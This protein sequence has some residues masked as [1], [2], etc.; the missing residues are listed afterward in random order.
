MA[1]VQGAPAEL[2]SFVG[3]ARE[4]ADIR[5]AL[6]ATRLLTLTGA[7]GSGKTRLALEVGA[8]EAA[9][10]GAA[11][12]WV[13]LAPVR[14]PALVAATVLA[15]LGI[16]DDSRL[17][18]LERL[19]RVI[20]DRTFTL[21]LDNC[22]HLVEASAALVDALLRAC[23]RLRVLVTSR[24]SLGV[25][26]ETA[27]LVPPLSL[28]APDESAVCTSEAVQL[29]VQRARAVTPGFELPAENRHAVVH[30]CRRLDGLPLA[31][32]LAA[33]RLR[34]LTPQQIAERLDDRF[35]LLRTG[36]RSALPRHQ[37][38][39]ATMD[40]SHDLLDEHERIALA[41]LSVFGGS[42]GI[43]AA[44]SV[45]AGG[46]I[47]GEDVLD[48]VAALVEKSLITM[49]ESDDIARYRLLETVREYAAERLEQR[50]E[51]GEC[52]RR[53]AQFFVALVAEAEPHLTTAARPGWLA[54]LDA[55]LDNIRQTLAWTREHDPESYVQ[56]T[57]MLHWFWFAS[58]QWP[59]ALQ[60]LRGALSLPAAA[61]RSHERAALLFSIGSILT[62]QASGD[63]CAYLE[64][65][66][67]IADELAD[68]R[69]VA[70]ARNYLGIARTQVGDASAE[71][72]VR[73]AHD[74]FRAANDLY[75]L[76]LSLLLLGTAHVLRGDVA[77]AVE[78]TEDG[79]RV[80]RIF[81][82]DRE[83]AIAL[84][85]LAAM[86][87]RRGDV[88]RATTLL[89]EALEALRRDPQRFFLARALEL[90]A[91]CL[92]ARGGSLD[93]A[94]LYGAAQAIRESIG[95]EIWGF[96][97]DQQVPH[98][99]AAEQSVGVEAFGVA[100][101]E[102]H[103]LQPAEAI[104]LA[105]RV[106]PALVPAREPDPSTNTAE[107]EV[108]VVDDGVPGRGT[109]PSISVRA[110]GPLEIAVDDAPLPR[111]SWGYAKARELLVFLLLYPEGRTR[112]QI[113]AAL[114][115]DASTAQVRNNFHVT[116]HH[117][118][119][120]L[121]RTQWIRFERDRYCV[122]P[123]GVVDFD[124][125]TFEAGVT[126][127][128]RLGRRGTLPLDDLGA[129]LALYRGPFLE[130]E[131]AGDWHL[132]W[133]DRF[134]RLNATGLEALGTALISRGLYDDA[135]ASFERLV[136]QEELHEPAYRSLIIARAR[137]GD[138]SG[139]MREYRRL[140][141]VLQREGE[142][143]PRAETQAIFRRVARGEAV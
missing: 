79:V 110:L 75:G 24:Q 118:R 55:E 22:E 54:R 10:S 126:N 7:G 19:A 36:N 51:V 32:E 84:Q 25:A 137:A 93:A 53:H 43:D 8:R 69:L 34:V 87:L 130:S 96:D 103:A 134:A 77:R 52:H 35:R 76:R 58:G 4:V 108:A 73:R 61:R 98:L 60:W 5:R 56:S 74:W 125:A 101:A 40:W 33:A 142:A 62:M 109:A 105:L 59:E 89:G 28:P 88:D 44:E 124:A 114:W 27:W 49:V 12:A 26:G 82:L 47:A 11:A 85:Q 135:A 107:F 1:T 45:C 112:E 38:L 94:R 92:A 50:G 9:A 63:G 67:A 37:T 21:I 90:M 139:A 116:L 129:A 65:A 131:P 64:E 138:R 119:R 2:T 91:M 141:A 72:P 136:H 39:R 111:K 102:G 3:R 106:A 70:Y 29:F 17:P 115:P 113:G 122:A 6:A 95:A 121:Q 15:A 30:I 81:G 42:F 80:A 23:P 14:D 133:R 57:G 143:A 71:L 66:E 128:L 97:R 120:A 123:L 78:V 86:V 13:E 127:A 99:A 48:L 140:E 18:P 117:L 83:L 16:R 31:L 132:E 41:R 20:G 68:C 46:V 100:R 104:D